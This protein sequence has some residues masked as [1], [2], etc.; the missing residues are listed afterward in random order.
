MGGYGDWKLGPDD[1]VEFE[2]MLAIVANYGARDEA[3]SSDLSELSSFSDAGDVSGWARHSV[4]WARAR[5]LASGYAGADGTRS[6]RP[7]EDVT[8]GR[9]AAV[10]ANACRTG[11]IV[12][13]TPEGGTM[14]ARFVDVGQGD[15]TVVELPYGK[16]MLVDA[17]TADAADEVEAAL[18]DAGHTSV[19][20]LVATHPH[21]G[22]IGGMAQVVRDFDIGEAWMTDVTNNT[23]TYGRLLDAPDEKGATVRSAAMGQAIGPNQAGYTLGVVGPRT[24]RYT[25]DPNDDSLIVGATY[26]SER[27]LL[28]GDA[29]ASETM[30]D[31]GH[32]VDVLKVSH[33]GSTT[34]TTLALARQVTPSVAVIS[35]GI[36]NSYGHP[37]QEVLD[38]LSAVG[39]SIY[40]TG[41]NGDVTVGTDGS[42]LDVTVERQGT[43]VAAGPADDPTPAADD[44]MT[45][46][47][48][49]TAS[50]KRFHKRGCSTIANSR[51]VTSMTRQ[52]ALNSGRTACRV[53]RP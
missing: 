11:V 36:G 41:A 45:Q 52:E 14:V 40:G 13:G 21:A 46:T 5:G 25:G 42:S 49:V 20:Y 51:T 6:L 34:G 9:A 12:V 16:V 8:R 2:Q 24:L 38:A 27:F 33:H 22:H 18:R 37:R 48:W 3:A 1:P 26:G 10:I 28:T 43:V 30:A 44:D 32:H 19:D 50:G 29:P 17:G 53:C 23:R 35:Y 47:V 7:H 15:A 39:T 31:V 4:A